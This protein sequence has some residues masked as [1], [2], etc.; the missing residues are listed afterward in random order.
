[1]KTQKTKKR[2]CALAAAFL[3]LGSL[4]PLSVF[5]EAAGEAPIPPYEKTLHQ[6]GSWN[7]EYV[8][9]GGDVRAVVGYRGSWVT[10]PELLY[11]IPDP[12]APIPVTIR[13]DSFITAIHVPYS[14]PS[15]LPDLDAVNAM[16]ID[17]AGNSYGPFLMTP[18]LVQG[19]ADPVFTTDADGNEV[20]AEAEP[21]DIYVNYTASIEDGLLVK[22]GE[23]FIHT[24]DN[25][26]IVRNGQTG[27]D[28]AAMVVGVDYDAWLKYMEAMESY[29]IVEPYDF[30]GR[31][32]INFET[33][34]TSTLMGPV[35]PPSSSMNLKDF[36]LT[37]LDQGEVIQLIGKY[38]GLPFSQMCPVIER[39]ENYVSATL[40]ASMDLTR[41]PYKAKIAGFGVITLE[42]PESGP[43]VFQLLGEGTYERA[44]SADKGADYNTYNMQA[45]G[46]LAGKDLPP[47]VTAALAGLMSK[48]G[49]VPG[50]DNAGQ[51]AVGALFPPLVAV[52]ANAIQSALLAQEKAKKAKAKAK[53]K[54]GQRDKDWYKDKYPGKTDEQ[55]AMIMLADAMGS[56]DNP[57]D[58]PLSVGDNE[59]SGSSGSSGTDSGGGSD[60]SWEEEYEEPTEEESMPEEA[61]EAATK[62]PSESETPGTPEEPRPET[63]AQPETPAEPETMKV[64]TDAKGTTVE[65]V[66]D[67]V[68]GEWVNPETGNTFNPE[69]QK[70]AE[71]GWEQDKEAIAKNRDVNDTSSSEWDQKLRNDDKARKDALEVANIQAKIMSKYGT[72]NVGD[73]LTAAG[74]MRDADAAVA[75]AYINAGKVASGFEQAAK[76]TV[77]VADAAVD[78]LG[79]ATGPVGRGIRAGYK[80]VKGVAETTAEQ[81]LSWQNVGSGLVKGGLDAGSD[82]TNPKWSGKAQQ[83]LKSGLQIGSEIV[84]E[85]T[86]SKGKGFVEG[87]KKGVV[88]AGL[89]AIPDAA[90]K[91]FGG[92]MLTTQLK[93]GQVRLARNTAGQWSGKVVTK[94][95]VE[96]FT[97][98]KTNRQLVQTG[99]KTVVNLTNEYVIKP[100]M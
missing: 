87:L 31:Y 20:V 35:N 85:T 68:T 48:A 50:P 94:N 62:V 36:E 45:S 25:S 42:K 80:T 23:Y 90:S 100:R 66:K 34:K 81:G 82:F 83:A 4:L 5:A 99:V 93:N 1:M 64:Q 54:S 40:E 38:E 19:E 97:K 26:R 74:K 76:V 72:K 59:T 33:L 67:P 13:S 75:N 79:N 60:D 15:E 11:S 21:R 51:A 29:G 98:Q 58:D 49:N 39:T 8:D 88:K 52:V 14:Y 18:Y 77:C 6:N 69:I 22:K 30:T 73:T 92:D 57:D 12:A 41:L 2:I 89:D 78:G 91:G 56:T 7:L 63:P 43:A 95:V 3:L 47:Y 96:N 28:G 46:V 65:F 17:S 61:E 44:A 55:L 53:K 16:V 37:I 71:L 32:S 86:S 84:G 24:T 70:T 10:D 27:Q 9:L